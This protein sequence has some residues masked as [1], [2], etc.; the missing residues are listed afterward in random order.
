MKTEINEIFLMTSLDLWL[1]SGMCFFFRYIVFSSIF[2]FSIIY[3]SPWCLKCGI[4]WN[5][6]FYFTET[7]LK[8]SSEARSNICFC[9]FSWPFPNTECSTWTCLESGRALMQFRWIVNLNQSKQGASKFDF[10]DFDSI[11]L[12]L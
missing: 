12:N 6:S 5:R 2:S 9:G 1:E 8:N 4:L 3:S 10:R 7:S 11:W